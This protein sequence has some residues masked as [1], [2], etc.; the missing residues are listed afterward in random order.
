MAG[1]VASGKVSVDEEAVL[2][3]KAKAADAKE[4]EK[5]ARAAGIKRSEEANAAKA[6]ATQAEII[7]AIGK[8]DKNNTEHWM[9]NGDPMVAAIET[10]LGKSIKAAQR[11]EA[12]KAMAAAK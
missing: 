6:P 7:G 4:R 8:L 11:N 1:F 12:V 9:E 5:K 3:R 10:V 2:A